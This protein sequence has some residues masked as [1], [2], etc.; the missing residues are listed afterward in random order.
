MGLDRVYQLR[1]LSNHPQYIIPKLKHSED[2]K[3]W[4]QS[5]TCSHVLVFIKK[6]TEPD[7]GLTLTNKLIVGPYANFDR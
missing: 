1:A 7:H 2:G 3:Q 5:S 4:I 6:D